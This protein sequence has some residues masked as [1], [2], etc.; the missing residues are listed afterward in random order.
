MSLEDSQRPSV[1]NTSG[2]NKMLATQGYSVKSLE[3]GNVVTTL[4]YSPSRFI[5]LPTNGATIFP[6]EPVTTKRSKI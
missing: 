4:N 5:V 6:I 3:A 2:Y 1:T